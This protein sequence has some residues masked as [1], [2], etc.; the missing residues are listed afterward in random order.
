MATIENQKTHKQGLKT[1]IVKQEKTK[2][3]AEYRC[4]YIV[5][6]Q[7]HELYEVNYDDI[8]IPSVHMELTYSEYGDEDFN[9]SDTEW[10]IGFDTGHSID[11]SITRSLKHVQKCLDKMVDEIINK[12]YK[13][14]KQA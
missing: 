5:I 1:F 10:I 11:N 7:G 9:F 2:Y 4:G 13:I 14:I 12:K 8:Y 3:M 6:P